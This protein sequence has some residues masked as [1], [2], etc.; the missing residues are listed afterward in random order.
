MGEGGIG[1]RL[2]FGEGRLA[3]LE[4]RLALGDLRAVDVALAS[5]CATRAEARDARA[6]RRGWSILVK[7]IYALAAIGG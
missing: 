1:A 7:V 6:M 4:V 2:N 3:R 5:L